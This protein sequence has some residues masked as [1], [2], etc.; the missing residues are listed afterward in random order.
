MNHRLPA[1][2]LPL[3][4]LS[5]AEPGPY[6]SKA[7][8]DTCDDG[9]GQTE[10]M[11]LKRITFA[12]ETDGVSVGFDLDGGDPALG[13][14]GVVDAVSPDGTEGID[15]SLARLLPALDNTEA[16]ALELVV[17]EAIH[18]GGLLVMLELGDVDDP[19]EDAC[20]DLAVTGALGQPMIGADGEVLPAQ[21]F[22]RDPDSSVSTVPEAQ[23]IDGVLEDGPVDLELPFAFLDAEVTFHVNNGRFRMTRHDDGSVTG[24]VGGGVAI[25]DLSDLAHNTGIAEEVEQVLDSLLGI[26]ADMAPDEN[27]DCQQIS[28]TIEFEAVPAFFYEQ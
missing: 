21:T 28:V 6:V 1:V 16:A 23:L 15:N 5:C 13:G 22:F 24:M 11:L 26:A 8:P 20:V 25:Q 10:R 18:A 4:L 19:Y 14:C 17:E 27:G 2:L 9:S 12:R 7:R 3:A